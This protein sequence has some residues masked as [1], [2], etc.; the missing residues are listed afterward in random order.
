MGQ[1]FPSDFQYMMRVE[2]LEW[3][4]K[5]VKPNDNPAK[6]GML[7]FPQQTDPSATGVFRINN[8]WFLRRLMTLDKFY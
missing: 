6:V 3:L 2:D 8:S 1:T 7:F 5:V 4:K